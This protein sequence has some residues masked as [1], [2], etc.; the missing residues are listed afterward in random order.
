MLP[1]S[2][3]CLLREIEGDRSSVSGGIA[4]LSCSSMVSRAG[5][6]TTLRLGPAQIPTQFGISRNKCELTERLRLLPLPPPGVLID[7][8]KAALIA[9][10]V[11][12]DAG[13]EETGS[14]SINEDDD[15]NNRDD[16]T[17]LSSTTIT[18]PNN[19]NNNGGIRPYAAKFANEDEAA[20][21][22]GE[23]SGAG[24]RYITVSPEHVVP[25]EDSDVED[26]R[27]VSGVCLFI[28][29]LLTMC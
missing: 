9:V 3:E 4:E 21:G 13:Q 12:G 23:Y 8:Y 11:V 1:E 22:G 26:E 10:S 15:D 6:Q 27:G 24:C 19:N 28:C 18:V 2:P 7:F 14:E 25:C 16:D 17:V 20:S 5:Y 29:L